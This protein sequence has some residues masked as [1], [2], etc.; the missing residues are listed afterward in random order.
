MASIN[1]VMIAKG[2][3]LL[4]YPGEP[5]RPHKAFVGEGSS[6]EHKLCLAG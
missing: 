2:Q 5:E 1:H 4:N 3:L 6:S